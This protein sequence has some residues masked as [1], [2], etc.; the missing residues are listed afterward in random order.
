MNKD[1]FVNWIIWNRDT[2]DWRPIYKFERCSSEIKAIRFKNNLEKQT[3][4]IDV[5]IT[6]IIEEK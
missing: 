1:Y 6:K 5:Y 2:P 3:S 4:F